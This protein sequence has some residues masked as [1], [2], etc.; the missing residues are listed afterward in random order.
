LFVTGCV[1]RLWVSAKK[2]KTSLVFDPT[3]P[4]IVHD[5][6]NLTDLPLRV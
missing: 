3:D 6:I 4:T 1:L 5:L 2:I